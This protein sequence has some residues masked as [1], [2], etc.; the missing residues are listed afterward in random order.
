MAKIPVGATI[1]GA[2]RFAFGNFL[3]IA[4]IVWLPWLF[5]TAVGLLLRPQT[6]AFSNALATRDMPAISGVLIVLA[7]VYLLTM[8]LLFMQIAGIMEQ[9]LGLRTGS[10]YFYFSIGKPV[11]RLIGAFLLMAAI[12]IGS[13]LLLLAAGILLGIV[14]A[15]LA[16]AMNFSG[17]LVAIAV[18]ILMIAAFCAYI[19]CL[20]RAS[21]LLNPIVIAEKRIS[22]AR[23]WALGEGNFWRIF[24][25]VLAVIGPL[26]AVMGFAMIGLLFHGLPPTLPL[27]AT[28][29]QIAA[30]RVMVAAWNT[31]MMKRMMD[32]WYLVYPAYGIATVLFYGLGCGAQSLAY[33]ALVP[34]A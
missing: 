32:H 30:N 31:A 16:K 3:A 20:V 21:F 22:L 23:S 19:Y 14:A 4:S 34:R 33:R 27:H 13:Y 25:I 8:F 26:M 11:W 18:G 7:P 6:L 24:L 5:I 1:A 10:P 17:S 2:Y 15:V 9:A 28:A 29:D 12:L